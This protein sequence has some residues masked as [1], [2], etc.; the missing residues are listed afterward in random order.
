MACRFHDKQLREPVLKTG[1]FRMLKVGETATCMRCKRVFTYF[2]FGHKFCP[3][4]KRIDD[5]QFDKIRDYIYQHGTATMVELEANTGVPIRRIEQYLREGRLEIPENS[6]I[7]IKCESCHCDIR[8]GRY[9]RECAG[10]LSKDLKGALAIDE[11]E[12]GE[13]PKKKVGKMRYLGN[14]Q[15]ANVKERKKR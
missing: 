7:Y 6:P 3:A 8:S 1:G 5:E 14:I 12:I 2:G 13:A 10:R 11:F 9:C 4:C 15:E